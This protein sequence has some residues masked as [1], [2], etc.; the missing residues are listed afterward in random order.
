VGTSKGRYRE[1]AG[2][3]GNSKRENVKFSLF[4]ILRVSYIMYLSFIRLVA[5]ATFSRE[6]EKVRVEGNKIRRSL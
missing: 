5:L 6:R 1:K 2:L 3:R 4:V